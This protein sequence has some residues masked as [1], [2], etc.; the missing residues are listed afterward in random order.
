M[1][2]TT[3]LTRLSLPILVV[4]ITACSSNPPRTLAVQTSDRHFQIS[5]NGKSKVIAQNN[6]IRA[7]QQT[8]RNRQP[9]ITHQDYQYDGLGNDKVGQV[10][11]QTG[12]VLGV[13]TGRNMDL[14]KDSD[15]TVTLDFYC[16]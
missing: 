7:A 10:L 14:S 6:A 1:A 11:Q 2:S 13:L 8:C 15:H 5:A 3:F 9:I 12:R 16:Q 4:L